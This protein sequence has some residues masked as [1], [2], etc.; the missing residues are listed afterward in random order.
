MRVAAEGLLG[1]L[2]TFL[3]SRGP[4]LVARFHCLLPGLSNPLGS[5]PPWV[6]A[7]MGPCTWGLFTPLPDWVP[8]LLRS[9]LKCHLLRGAFSGPPD[10]TPLFKRRRPIPCFKYTTKGLLV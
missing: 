10:D 3:V 6:L 1:C 5:F 2:V 9:S 7:Q 8:F 4:A